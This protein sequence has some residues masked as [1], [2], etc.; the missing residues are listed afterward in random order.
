MNH[1]GVLSKGW[2]GLRGVSFEPLNFAKF[3]TV[4]GRGDSPSDVHLASTLLLFNPPFFAAYLLS[5]FALLSTRY[6]RPCLA[7]LHPD[8]VCFSRHRCLCFS[9]SLP[10][11]SSRVSPYPLSRRGIMEILNQFENQ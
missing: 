2:S 5:P 8:P 11:T 7:S 9:F 6:T 4:R 10:P 3:E 1:G